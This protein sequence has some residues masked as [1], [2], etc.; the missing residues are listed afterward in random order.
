MTPDLSGPP[1]DETAERLLSGA[2]DEPPEA[3]ARL[4]SALTSPTGTDPLREESAVGAFRAS[5]LPR[6]G[7]RWSDRAGRA[8]LSAIVAGALL[9]GGAVAAG[10]GVVPAPFRPAHAKSPRPPSPP[11]VSGL[12][13]PDRVRPAGSAPRAPASPEASSETR[14]SRRPPSP[15]L[16]ASETAGK[17]ADP[18]G[19]SKKSTAPKSSKTK[20]PKPSK[21]KKQKKK[22]GK[23]AAA[24]HSAALDTPDPGPPP[25]PTGFRPP[26]DRARPPLGRPG[27][28][29]HVPRGPAAGEPAGEPTAGT[30]GAGEPASGV[31]ATGA[32]PRARWRRP[33]GSASGSTGSVPQRLLRLPA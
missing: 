9:V 13:L 10:T 24:R 28:G 23:K 6:L 30:P 29:S 14:L 15:S 22:K 31:P 26:P 17:S 21:T 7:W 12:P 11:A 1:D 18:G 25:A 33:S 32:G 20:T 16:S 3:V 19:S 8:G 4:L 5:R 27:P 2:R